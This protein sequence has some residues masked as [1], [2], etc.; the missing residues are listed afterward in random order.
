MQS[1]EFD[2]HKFSLNSEIILESVPVDQRETKVKFVIDTHK[3]IKALGLQ[4]QPKTDHFY[5][6][7]CEI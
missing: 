6:S 4:L 1:G 5:L 7:T 2:L 3:T